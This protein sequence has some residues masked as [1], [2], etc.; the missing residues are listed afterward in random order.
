M[1]TL[2]KSSFAEHLR[3]IRNHSFEFYAV[4]ESIRALFMEICPA[5]TEEIRYGGIV[6]KGKFRR[7]IKLHETGDI[8]A[9][10][11]KGFI[12]QSCR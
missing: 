7:H 2:K 4:V 11:I 3:D 9:K 5:C 10:H 8:E 6:G 1:M 12:E